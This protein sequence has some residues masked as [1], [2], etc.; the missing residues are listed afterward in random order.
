M[1][2][3]FK[4]RLRDS[5][6]ADT[7]SYLVKKNLCL[8]FKSKVCT[9]AKWM[10]S[11]N[12]LRFSKTQFNSSNRQEPSPLLYSID[13][14]P[15]RNSRLTQRETNHYVAHCASVLAWSYLAGR[16]PKHS[17]KDLFAQHQRFTVCCPLTNLDAKVTKWSNIWWTTNVTDAHNIID[18][19]YSINVK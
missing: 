15:T 9:L 19:P 5:F 17:V 8:L 10:L 18:W 1:H 12:F 6:S 3:R 7:K 4:E 11:K 2:S 16:S 13:I 14:W